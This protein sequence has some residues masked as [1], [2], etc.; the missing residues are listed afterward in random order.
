M[1][2][3]FVLFFSF[4][5]GPVIMHGRH[6]AL[7][8]QVK[9]PHRGGNGTGC[10]GTAGACREGEKDE[11]GD[12]LDDRGGGCSGGAHVLQCLTLCFSFKGCA[13][14]CGL[15]GVAS[16]CRQKCLV[17]QDL[18][19][20]IWIGECASVIPFSSALWCA[21]I[22]EGAWLDAVSCTRRSLF[23]TLF[24]FSSSGGFCF[25]R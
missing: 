12:V 5:I 7:R 2:V 17:D 14:A 6:E 9:C 20:N 13:R 4:I 15:V 24:F 10:C 16:A 8:V 3:L 11:R 21:K 19:H 25:R 18:V 22:S 23:P 1:V